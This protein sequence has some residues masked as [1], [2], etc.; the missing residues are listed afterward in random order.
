MHHLEDAKA[1]CNLAAQI[2]G[3]VL[4]L[5]M[6]LLLHDLKT[7]QN[8][9]FSSSIST[10]QAELFQRFRDFEPHAPLACSLQPVTILHDML[11]HFVCFLACLFHAGSSPPQLQPRESYVE[12]QHGGAPRLLL[13][14]PLEAPFHG[15]PG[16]RRDASRTE[17]HAVTHNPQRG[18]K[19]SM[20]NG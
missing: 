10:C 18:S 8:T 6:L 15:T 2:W 4:K 13:T 16:Q 19:R 17:Q 20:I 5:S 9:S 3:K 11:L 1:P 12:L 14:W 7:I